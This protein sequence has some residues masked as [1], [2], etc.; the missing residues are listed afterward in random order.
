MYLLSCLASFALLLCELD[1]V[2]LQL[3]PSARVSCNAQY[4][5]AG[6]G[7][8]VGW[9]K[10]SRLDEVVYIVVPPLVWAPMSSV[11]WTLEVEVWLP[12][13]SEA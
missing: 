3:A 6:V 2:V 10:S 5:G 1:E 4:S 7:C 8:V 9:F 12:S 13:V 11:S